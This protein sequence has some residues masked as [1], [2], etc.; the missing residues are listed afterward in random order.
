[1]WYFFIIFLLRF[2][3]SWDIFT[4][5]PEG[6]RVWYC[7]CLYCGY[8]V[9]CYIHVFGYYYSIFCIYL[10]WVCRNFVF[11]TLNACFWLWSHSNENAE[12][13][14]FILKCFF[15]ALNFEIWYFILPWAFRPKCHIICLYCRWEKLM[16]IVCKIGAA[17]KNVC[18]KRVVG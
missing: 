6:M 17:L 11:Y 14:H 9:S 15:N 5:S 7:L 1:M 18:R 2:F 13:S 12:K 3:L 10:F 4:T 16:N 8:R